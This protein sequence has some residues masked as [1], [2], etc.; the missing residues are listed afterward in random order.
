M[1]DNI[2]DKK[3]AHHASCAGTLNMNAHDENVL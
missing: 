3:K 2:E 1:D